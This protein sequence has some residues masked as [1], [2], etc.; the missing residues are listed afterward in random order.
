MSA[1]ITKP[2]VYPDLPFDQYAAIDAINASLLKEVANSPADAWWWRKYGKE[3]TEAMRLGSARHCALLEPHRF[4][5][6]YVQAGQCE[7]TVKSRGERCEH[8][9]KY[10]QG[11][12]WFC[13]KHAAKDDAGQQWTDEPRE[14]FDKLEYNA[15]LYIAQRVRND[16]DLWPL[17]EAQDAMREVVLVWV[18]PPT[19]RPCK[20]RL[21]LLTPSLNTVFDLKTTGL[22]SRPRAIK[23]AAKRLRFALQCAHIMAGC[24]ELVAEIGA[25]IS[26]FI[27]GCIESQ[28]PNKLTPLLVR[29]ETLA[30][31]EVERRRTI[32]TLLECERT[33]DW[34]AYVSERHEWPYLEPEDI[35][36]VEASESEDEPEIDPADLAEI[37]F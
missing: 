9:G 4:E 12:R 10:Y 21:D 35:V 33:G 24:V 7:A 36:D 1:T 18:D 6:D 8:P 34:P 32:D 17:F 14:A 16:H 29:P 37:A 20:A 2:G 5:R 13:G 27:F 31:A 23:Y 30:V 15:C 28:P 22:S 25:D 3:Q 19:Q 11:G 26:Q